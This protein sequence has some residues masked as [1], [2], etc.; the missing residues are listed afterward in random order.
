M[1]VEDLKKLLKQADDETIITIGIDP[2][3]G[4]YLSDTY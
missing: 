2:L 1:T 3:N 4:E